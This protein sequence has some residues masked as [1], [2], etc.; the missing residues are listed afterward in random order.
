M[1]GVQKR[2]SA[3]PGPAQGNNV[4]NSGQ[5]GAGSWQNLSAADREKLR[6]QLEASQ[7]ELQAAL[8]QIDKI[9]TP[10]QVEFLDN[11]N[12]DETPYL[13]RRPGGQSSQQLAEVRKQAEAARARLEK[14]FTQ[15]VDYLKGRA[16]AKK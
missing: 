6:R 16:K 8:D 3:E 2:L 10:G 11:L 4:A 5:G 9:L 13:V 12:F 1:E 15:T 14:L 7:R